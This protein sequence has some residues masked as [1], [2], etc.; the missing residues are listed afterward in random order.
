MSLNYRVAGDP[1]APMYS[2]ERDLAYVFPALIQE[3]FASLDQEKW[4]DVLRYLNTEHGLTELMLAQ[5]CQ[6]L[7]DVFKH[8]LRD[9][10]V[11]TLEEAIVLA[12]FR[13]QPALVQLALF[14]RLGQATAAGTLVAAKTL[15]PQFRDGGLQSSIGS[16]VATMY[17]AARQLTGLPAQ[18]ERTELDPALYWQGQAEMY[19]RLAAQQ[20]SHI[21]TLEERLLQYESTNGTPVD[22]P[23]T[24]GQDS[25]SGEKTDGDRNSDDSGVRSA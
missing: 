20:T 13:E 25:V 10:K 8:F 24:S 12:K 4:D 17:Q 7:A 11:K 22:V 2:P 18:E 19:Q 16:L 14:Y 9:N 1:S 23:S 3:V 6:A 15:T 21:Q 5:G